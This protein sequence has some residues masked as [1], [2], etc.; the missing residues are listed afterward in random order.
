MDAARLSDANP[1]ARDAFYGRIDP[2]NM[3]PLWTRLIS[4]VPVAP[5]PIGVPHLWR[6]DDVRPFVLESATHISAEEAERRVLIL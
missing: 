1:E 5:T 4:L 2:H 3:A 6:Y